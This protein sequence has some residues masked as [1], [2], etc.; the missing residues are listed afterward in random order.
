ML[1]VL[2]TLLRKLDGYRY[3]HNIE[4]ALALHFRGEVR[5]DGLKT[6]QCDDSLG[7]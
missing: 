4:R 6:R 1:H 3:Q 7:D 2:E 5:S